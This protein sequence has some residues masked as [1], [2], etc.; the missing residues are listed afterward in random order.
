ML[1]CYSKFKSMLSFKGLQAKLVVGAKPALREDE[2]Q[3]AKD[4][5]AQ[6]ALTAKYLSNLEMYEMYIVLSNLG[7]R[8]S[9]YFAIEL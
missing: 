2:L 3:K 1:Q 5:L 6:K 7:L 4:F 9:E 8:P